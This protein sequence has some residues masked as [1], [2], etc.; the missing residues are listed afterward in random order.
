[1]EG[2]SS[3]WTL[4]RAAKLVGFSEE[5]RPSMFTTSLDNCQVCSL[6]SSTLQTSVQT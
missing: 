6:A 1:M 3:G 5:R 2:R 4:P